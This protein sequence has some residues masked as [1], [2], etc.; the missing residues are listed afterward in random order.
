MLRF[1]HRKLSADDIEAIETAVGEL[2]E[3]HS[4]PQ[5]ILGVLKPLRRAARRQR[6]AA[7]SLIA[8]VNRQSLP[9]ADAL[10]CVKPLREWYPD[11]LSLLAALGEAAESLVDLNFLNA[12]APTDPFLYTLVDDLACAANDAVGTADES[13]LLAGTATAARMLGRQRDDVAADA[14][15]RLVKLNPQGAANHY[16]LGLFYKTRGRFEEGVRANQSARALSAT[17]VESY[18]W[19]LGI[20]ATGAGNGPLALE[21]W[22]RMQQKI[23]MGRFELPE[24]GYPQC[25]VRLAQRPLAER[26]TDDDNPGHEETIWIERLSP[27]HGVVRSVLYADLGVDFGDVVLIDGAPITYHRYGDSEVPVFPHLATLVHSGYRFYDFAGTQETTMQVEDASEDL[28]GD[29]V[30][31]SHTERLETICA[32]CW[33]DPDLEHEHD[34]VSEENV[35]TG[36]IAAPPSIEPADLLAQIDAAMEKRT[37]CRLFA[38]AL[39]R[40]AGQEERARFEQRRFD[41]LAGAD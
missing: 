5:R 7:V 1:L 35:V 41:V 2:V 28:Q 13:D 10:E 3:E 31:Y 27:C 34:E 11:D 9:P 30:I 24:G 25:K 26:S 40:A 20:C 6:E 32:S 18:E 17:P 16:N 19:N 36:R 33:R 8:V 38:P 39:C 37:P 15:Q 22:E 12:A 29:S 23:A 14:Y 21:V 4:E